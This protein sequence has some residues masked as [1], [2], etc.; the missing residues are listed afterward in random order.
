M[1]RKKTEK[2]PMDIAID[3]QTETPG[4]DDSIVHTSD[5][6]EQTNVL[7]DEVAQEHLNIED[8]PPQESDTSE[9]FYTDIELRAIETGW[10]P[11]EAYHGDEA[12]WRDAKTWNDKN[13]TLSLVEEQR[14]KIEQMEKTQI[15]ML[16]MMREERARANEIQ[17]YKLEKDKEDAI[18]LADVNAVRELD[19]SISKLRAIP[20]PSKQAPAEN[21]QQVPNE[22]TEFVGR[23]KWFNGTDELSARKTLY[24]KALEN[25][26]N[27]KKSDMSLSEKMLHIE[28][29]VAKIFDKSKPVTNNIAP[30]ENR[31]TT[32]NT[33]NPSNGLPSYESLPKEAQ[34]L[35]EY[36]AKKEEFRAK[37][38]NK[39]FNINEYRAR[40]VRELIKNNTI[41]GKGIPNVKGGK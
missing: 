29:E 41:D 22:V 7:P 37:R 30:V 11:K 12:N 14:R 25:E 15:E 35:I 19:E 23:N 40:Y 21:A 8:S 6:G 34:K 16:Q 38:N 24:A 39:A 17:I 27:I 33:R 28:N 5:Y 31:R 20:G 3:Q 32:M 4:Q 36:Y 10:V 2:S 26:L 18:R 13:K 9:S 1:A